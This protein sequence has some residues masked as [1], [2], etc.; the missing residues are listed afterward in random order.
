M[1]KAFAYF[2]NRGNLD[3]D[4]IA[5]TKR[6]CKIKSIESG[7]FGHYKVPHNATDEEIDLAL[8]NITGGYGSVKSVKIETA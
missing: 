5:L 8:L 3:I 4:T 6:D 1:H 2:D 7:S